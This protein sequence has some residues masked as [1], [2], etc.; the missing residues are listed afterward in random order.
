LRIHDR[1]PFDLL[2]TPTAVP[3]P[4]SAL[5]LGLGVAVFALRRHA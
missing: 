5:L 4:A 1:E 2:L 3:E